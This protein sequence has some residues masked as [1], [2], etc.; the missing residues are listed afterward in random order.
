M[1]DKLIVR[2]IKKCNQ[3][4]MEMLIDNYNG[5]LTSVVKKHISPLSQYE[6][7]CISDILFQ[8]WENID[9]FNIKENSFK[10]WICAIAKYKAID[11]KRK[12]INKASTEIDN[13]IPYIDENLVSLEIKEE[14][15]EI[16][17][18]LNDKD[19]ELFT[20]YYLYG[21][22]LEEIAIQFDTNVT[23]LHSRLSRGRKRIRK[24]ILK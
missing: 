19:K 4:G 14:I 15:K 16:L 10:N 23:N 3:K 20:R 18:I 2:H 7:D 9:S 1:K 6:E 17:S 5:L 11:Y 22:K 24:N 21:E 13:K 8:I 12:Y